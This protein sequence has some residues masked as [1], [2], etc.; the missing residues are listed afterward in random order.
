[1]GKTYTFLGEPVVGSALHAALEA[2]GHTYVDAC[3]DADV[4]FTY[5]AHLGAIED[6]YFDQEGLIKSAHPKT[7]LV[8]LSASTPSLAREISA[9]ATV[10]NLRFVEAPLA[11]HDIACADAFTFDNLI[12]FVAGED[13]DV[14]EAA[15]LLSHVASDVRL[16]GTVG[17]GALAKVAHTIQVTA[18]AISVVETQ[19]LFDAV[20]ASSTSVDG[21]DAAVRANDESASGM[22]AAIGEGRLEGSYTV[23]LLMG[24]VAAAMTAADDVELIVPQ[25]ES[26]MHLLEMLAIIGGADMTPSALSLLYRPEEVGQAAGL[27]WNRAQGVL[28]PDEHDH[29]H[30]HDHDDGYIHLH[31][32][33]MDFGLD[34]ED[35]DYGYDDGYGYP[36][37]RFS[38]N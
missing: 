15:E 37:G 36:Y 22:L 27:D 18:Q 26:G 8:D 10:S 7:L 34:D 17:R 16:C 25:L 12:C 2:Q 29:D 4:V 20:R 33:D 38:E 14:A 28:I 21:L 32:D 5:G 24:D 31:G 19:A 23:A 6:A 35:D 30:D 13:D 1:M 9:V 11:L 3:A